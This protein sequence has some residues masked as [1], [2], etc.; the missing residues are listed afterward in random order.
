MVSQLFDPT[1]P[2]NASDIAIV[3]VLAYLCALLYFLPQ[4]WKAPVFAVIFLFWRAC[5]NVGI[6]WLLHMQS[7]HKRLVVWAKKSHIFE[8][9][10][11]GKN[12]HP[13]L[14]RF[15]KQEMET[16]IPRDYKF[17]NAP[18]E[19]N[20]WLMFRRL[21]DLILMCDFTSYCLFAIACGSHP[22]GEKLSMTIAR[23]V[24]GLLLVAFNL[25]VKLDAH[26]V[27]GNFAWSWGDCFFLIDQ[28]LT[29]DGVYELAPHPMYSVGYCGYYGIS[30][31]AA[32]YNVLFISIIA[33]AAQL[34]FL[35][36]VESPHIERTYN[37]P[38]GQK[39]VDTA[40]EDN[41]SLDDV[42]HGMDDAQFPPYKTR[43]MSVGDPYKL[44]TAA[45]QPTSPY[46]TAEHRSTP[47]HGCF[48]DSAANLH[49]HVCLLHAFD[50]AMANLLRRQ[51][52]SLAPVVFD[53]YR[54]YSPAT[55]EQ[56][57][58][59]AALPQVRRN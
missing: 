16:K 43:L 15:L 12:P 7:H 56:E 13:F 27:V 17:E 50:Y 18:I 21:V 26:R 42:K 51:R 39:R 30:M 38:P 5:Y 53:R 25:W 10:D 55:V 44:A 19:F 34:I 29:F 33:H 58:V 49:V 45:V 52:G 23:W 3:T 48:G 36:L 47:C 2:K 46:R 9:P 4:S 24:G 11:T 37:A 40:P 8:N 14:Y 32:S 6:G 35:V 28:E 20:T 54:L 31:M 1:Q 22:T 41:T 57:A 59:D